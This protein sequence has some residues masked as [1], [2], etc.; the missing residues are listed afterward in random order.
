VVYL[1]LR[2]QRPEPDAGGP[3]PDDYDGNFLHGWVFLRCVRVPVTASCPPHLHTAEGL[4]ADGLGRVGEVLVQ[5]DDARGIA[6]GFV[7][8]G[9]ERVG[10][11]QGDNARAPAAGLVAD[12]LERCAQPTGNTS[13]RAKDAH[14]LCA[15]STAAKHV[16]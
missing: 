14:A 8:D 10:Q 6:E 5:V 16:V 3:A 2:Q 15:G 11:A 4:V 9:L 13:P 12:G 7:A 1:A